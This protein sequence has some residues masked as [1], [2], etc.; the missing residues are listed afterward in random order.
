MI[1]LASGIADVLGRVVGAK[2]FKNYYVATYSVI[3]VILF[4]AFCLNMYL[5]NFVVFRSVSY[6][7][8]FIAFFN[9]M[10]TS[11]TLL[12]YIIRGNKKSTLDNQKE[13][14]SLLSNSIAT[15]IALGNLC[16]NCLPFIREALL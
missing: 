9:Y 6:F 16:S 2:L 1:N 4:D 7:I 15:G 13:I 10:R 12:Y 14:G 11:S 8:I 3:F 5:G